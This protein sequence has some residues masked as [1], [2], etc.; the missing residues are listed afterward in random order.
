MRKDSKET[1]NTVAELNYALQQS[2]EMYFSE[3]L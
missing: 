2:G 1:K 3:H